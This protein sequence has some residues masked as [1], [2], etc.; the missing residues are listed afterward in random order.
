MVPMKSLGKMSYGGLELMLILR[1]LLDFVNIAKLISHLHL[2]HL[3]TH[4]NGQLDLGQSY[5]LT[6]LGRCVTK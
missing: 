4:G 6:M 2:L 1:E 5:T 3:Y